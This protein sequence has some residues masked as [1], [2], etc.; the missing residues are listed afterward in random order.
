M[1][2]VSFGD[3]LK[4]RRN[5]QGI[6]QDQLA[7]QINCST[8]LLR[9]IEA[10][11]RRPSAQM[12]EQIVK[13]FN[14]PTGERGVFLQFAR[15]DWRSAPVE[16]IEEAP[17]RAS[18]K[19]PRLNLP[20]T[21]TYL[22]GREKE[23]AL[24][25]D[26]LLNPNIRL[27]TLMGPPGIGKTHLS[28][29]AARVSS[30][31]FPDGVFFVALASLSDPSLIASTIIQSLGYAEVG[32]LPPLKQLTDGIGAKQMLVVLDNCE[33]L[34]EELAPF[35]SGLLS[36][37]SRL[38]IFA[39]SRESLR[40]PGEW[41]YSLP[42]LDIP[43]E[44]LL[45]DVK[46]AS[47]F[48]AMILFAERARAVRSDFTLDAANIQAVASICK[49]LDGLPLAIELVAARIRLMSL[50]ALQDRLGDH[51]VMSASGMRTPSPRQRTL[52]DAIAWSFNLLSPEEQ[53]LFAYLSV[54]TGGFTLEAAESTFSELLINK[55]VRD[56]LASLHDKSLIR[57][58]MDESGG[59]RYD[60]LVTIQQFS[61]S[62]LR[63]MDKEPEIRN[64]HLVYF[65]NLA[66]KGDQEMRGPN[67]IIWLNRLN[68][69]RDDLRAALDWAIE[70]KQPEA[71]L[72]FARNLHW[73]WNMTSDHNEGRQWIE[74]I[75]ELPDVSSYRQLYGSVLTQL[76]HHKWM[77]SHR[78]WLQNGT[79]EARRSV[80]QALA[81]AREINDRWDIARA[82]VW[83]GLVLVDEQDF[84][85]AQS[86]LE[87]CKVIFREVH[88]EWGY[89]HAIICLALA[90]YVQDD[91]SASLTLNEQALAG[92][93]EIGDRY[94][95]I[96]ALRYISGIKMNQG[97]FRYGEAALHEALILS[98]QLGGKIEIA[99]SLWGAA[100]AAI[101]L[102]Q[103]LRAVH[104]YC[105]AKKV[106]DS[107][108]VWGE[109][110]EL[111]FE[112]SLDPCRAAL[113]ETE[114][115]LAL[116]QSRAMTT[117]QAIQYALKE[118]K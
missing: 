42:A 111:K 117:E 115:T 7:L 103:P 22:I 61:M 59:A 13:I 66:Q 109:E 82:L 2:D 20:A 6:T 55:P 36:A 90:A 41:Q 106:Y 18:T 74:R 76:A 79:N 69:I 46:F 11:E 32:N 35:V 78:S 30:S 9:K 102:N 3:W 99:M 87:E 97:D 112:K 26:Y 84:V 28:I 86:T 104:L 15:G 80:M 40:I 116:E 5:T 65:L 17:W 64:A 52:Q 53:E 100:E 33:H 16:S 98:Q 91:L 10:E 77:L 43:K 38:K 72:Q 27:V 108:G 70:S 12:V 68:A 83:L 93:R 56:L 62:C 34:I 89:T 118:M 25:S 95:M 19:S 50:Q 1:T 57:S 48:P 24:L 47:Q 63:R 110:D 45:A 58:T 4:R 14:I 81:V 60:M 23:I 94:F 85:L 29:E 96:V 44:S 114:F 105:M 51:V 107:I 113:L 101:S 49:Q 31:N 21:I 75:L 39:T 88:D 8:S 37:C 67:Q 54:F 71:A 73:F 92:F